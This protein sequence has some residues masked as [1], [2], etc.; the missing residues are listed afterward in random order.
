M[1]PPAC[2]SQLQE[3][4]GHARV[5]ARRASYE[6]TNSLPGKHNM[7]FTI[8]GTEGAKELEVTQF[9]NTDIANHII[10]D[11]ACAARRIALKGRQLRRNW[12]KFRYGP[13]KDIVDAATAAGIHDRIAGC[14]RRGRLLFDTYKLVGNGWVITARRSPPTN[15]R[16]GSGLP[17]FL[18][19]VGVAT[20]KPTTHSGYEAVRW[21][22]G[23]QH[24]LERAAKYVPR[25]IDAT[26]NTSPRDATRG[27]V[28][29]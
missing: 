27:L 8:H 12:V 20:G 13:R 26:E 7:S 5:F 18:R 28:D 14:E 25:A 21:P 29:L 10:G 17:P 4:L 19:G 6:C 22:G 11:S 23:R 2:G 9:R 1:K 3:K 15:T 24:D 16:R